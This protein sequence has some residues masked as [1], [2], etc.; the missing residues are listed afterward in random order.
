MYLPADVEP[1]GEEGPPAPGALEALLDALAEELEAL[2]GVGVG[3][4]AAV[5]VALVAL[6]FPP[7]AGLADV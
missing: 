3:P 4:P 2:T 7:P 6:V 1:D 5:P